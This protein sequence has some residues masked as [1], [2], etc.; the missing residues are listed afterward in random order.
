M[1]KF[2]Y[3]D[4]VYYYEITKR[5]SCESI[6]HIYKE[7][8]G[9]WSFF[10]KYKRIIY[11]EYSDSFYKTDESVIKRAFELYEEKNKVLLI[12]CSPEV[13]DLFNR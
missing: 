4:N 8:V 13:E 3:K 10:D 9:F 7:R 1:K 11:F 2:I 5:F 12:D 6:I